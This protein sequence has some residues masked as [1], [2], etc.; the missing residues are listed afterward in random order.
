LIQ[1]ST[2]NALS[3]EFWEASGTNLA[4]ALSRSPNTTIK[5]T[6]LPTLNVILRKNAFINWCCVCEDG[7]LRVLLCWQHFITCSL[8]S[9]PYSKQKQI[10]WERRNW[11]LNLVLGKWKVRTNF[12]LALSLFLLLHTFFCLYFC[13][14]LLLDG[15]IS[16]KSWKLELK[17]HLRICLLQVCL[18]CIC[19]SQLSPANC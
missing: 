11:E 19:S 12:S 17:N 2:D 5:G 3:F 16:V 15:L 4:D 1:L 14:S 6:K 8:R 9:C 10:E 18:T 7:L 13:L